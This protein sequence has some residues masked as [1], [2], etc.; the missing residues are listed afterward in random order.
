MALPKGIRERTRSTFGFPATVIP[1]DTIRLIYWDEEGVEHSL[2]RDTIDRAYTFTEGVI[3]EADAG[4]F[5]EGAAL[6]G[7]FVEGKRQ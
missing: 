6:G 2:T 3:F 4:V 7:A 1:G 5:G